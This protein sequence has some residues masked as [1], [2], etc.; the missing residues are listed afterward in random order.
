MKDLPSKDKGL[1]ILFL[2]KSF[3]LSAIENRF[4]EE[5]SKCGLYKKVLG[6]LY[7]IYAKGEIEQRWIFELYNGH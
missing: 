3:E 6:D 2:T 4:E 7:K 5:I 1:L